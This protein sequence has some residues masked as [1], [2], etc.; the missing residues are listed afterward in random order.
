MQNSA[1]SKSVS[2]ALVDFFRCPEDAVDLRLDVEL[3][4]EPGYF[5]FGPE[6]ICF[7][8]SSSGKHNGELTGPLYDALH[9]TRTNAGV[10][11]LTFDPAQVIENLRRELYNSLAI[12]K[13]GAWKLLRSAYYSL[14]PV[15]P[16]ALRKHVQ[17]I[18]LRDWGR[19]AFPRWPVDHTVENLMGNLMAA[20]IR[21]RGTEI[22]FIW[23][24]PDGAPSGLILTHDVETAK[25]LDFCRALIDVD[26]RYGFKSSFQIVPE[27]RYSASPALLREIRSQGCEINVHDLNHDGLLFDDRAEFL[28]RV[29]KINQYGKEFQSVGFRSGAMYRRVDWFGDLEFEYDMSVPC[30]GHLE[31]QRGGCC[32]V[33]PYFIERILELPLTTI[34]DYALFHYLGDYSIDLWKQQIDQ[35]LLKNGLISIIV[36]PDYVMNDRARKAY[37]A[38][39]THLSDLRSRHGIWAALP[40]EV[41]TWW[42]QRNQMRLVRHGNNWQISGDGC[43]RARLAFASLQDDRLTFR[44]AQA[45][46]T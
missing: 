43:Q 45:K 25:G 32:T 5:Q 24:W 29:A 33:M 9:D 41:N 46:Q 16:I 35:I 34:Q 7:G 18:Y 44:V 39:L 12:S 37:R 38:L 1:N 22:P 27:E 11:H 21:A 4:G 26:S 30:V 20:A 2:R 15:L 42:R 28:R 17:K 6:T 8:L 10:V 3:S 23:F 31:P 36:H 14:R 13:G 19:I 40:G